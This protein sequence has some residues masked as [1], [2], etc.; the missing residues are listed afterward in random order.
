MH[1]KTAEKQKAN[2][3]FFQLNWPLQSVCSG[4]HTIFLSVFHPQYTTVAVELLN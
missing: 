1:T 4:G 2:E 3:F